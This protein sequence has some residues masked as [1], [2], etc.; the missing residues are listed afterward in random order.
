MS[1]RY[2]VLLGRM[3]F[4]ALDGDVVQAVG[5][6]L[7]S[8]GGA[9]TPGDRRPKPF[10][11]SIPLRGDSG[12]TNPLLVAQRT[13]RQIRS[14]IANERATSQGTFFKWNVDTELD[15]WLMIGGADIT[16]PE[17]GEGIGFGEWMLSMDECFAVGN[18]RTHRPAMRVVAIYYLMCKNYL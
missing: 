5:E 3:K 13:R 8:M 18:K 15:G 9:V 17:G 12:E 10:S 1:T 14:L 4:V 16:D 11:L 2:D 6:T 7:T